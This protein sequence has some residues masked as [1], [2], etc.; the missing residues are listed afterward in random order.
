MN[1]IKIIHSKP[2]VI[3]KVHHIHFKAKKTLE[4]FDPPQYSN[5]HKEHQRIKRKHENLLTS[6]TSIFVSQ[7]KTNNLL[8]LK[9]SSPFVISKIQQNK[10]HIPFF[11][12]ILLEKLQSSKCQII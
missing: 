11:F 8:K 10:K 5:N 4:S 1:K 12:W 9:Q 7:N 6:K 2:N 3:V